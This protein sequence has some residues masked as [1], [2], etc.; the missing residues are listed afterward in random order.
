[1]KD[2]RLGERVRVY[3][4]NGSYTATITRTPSYSDGIIGVKGGSQYFTVHAKQ[5]RRLKPRRKARRIWVNEEI[6]RIE[7][8][9]KPDRPGLTEFLEVLRKEEN[10]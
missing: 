1:M 7:H 8:Q 10:K 2:P 9:D 3:N 5:C 6:C 4:S